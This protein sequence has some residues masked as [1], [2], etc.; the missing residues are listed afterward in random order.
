MS[1]RSPPP[2]D[3]AKQDVLPGFGPMP[4][5]VAAG[6]GDQGQELWADRVRQALA[7]RSPHAHEVAE[8]AL[9]AWPASREL[10]LGLTRFG[11][12]PEAFA[13]GVPDA[14]ASSAVLT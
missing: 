4:D 2:R 7:E 14:Q 3:A 8:E 6:A 12:H 9:R 1:S 13:R 10:G 5:D 11:G